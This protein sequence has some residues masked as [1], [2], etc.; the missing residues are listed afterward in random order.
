MGLYPSGHRDRLDVAI[1]RS[2]LTGVGQTVRQLSV[3]N[4]NDMDCDLMEITAHAGARPSHAEWQ[5]QLVSLSGKNAGRKID[6]ARVYSLREIGYGTGDGFG[7]WNCRHDW[8]PFFEGISSRAYSDKR[9]NELNARDIEYDGKMYTEYEIDQMQ[10]ALERDVR[11]CK[12]KVSAADTAV[13]NAS[14]EKV[15]QQMR[16]LFTVESVKLKKAEKKL[17][18]FLETTGNLSDT[19][20]TGVNGFNRSTAQNAVWANKKGLTPK[21]KDGKINKNIAKM[22]DSQLSKSIKSWTE[23]IELHTDKIENPQ[24]YL[25]DWEN[26]DSRYQDGLKKHWKKEKMNFERDRNLAEDELKKR[27]E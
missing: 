20:R 3:I 26:F 10:R 17:D 27:G 22:T 15:E 1:R 18:G 14:D 13:K 2:A 19:T 12:R 16:D 8:F 6:G 21:E 9:L 7:G 25:P 24:K 5:G 11:D 4:A 23:L